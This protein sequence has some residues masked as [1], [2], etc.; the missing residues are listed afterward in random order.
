[1]L[2]R[3]LSAAAA[4]ALEGIS[5]KF[6][7]HSQYRVARRSRVAATQRRHLGFDSMPRLTIPMSDIISCASPLVRLPS[8]S[9]P[10]VLNDCYHAF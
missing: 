7:L 9:V 4:A 3:L 2:L 6:N 1:M 5:R 10:C 8:T